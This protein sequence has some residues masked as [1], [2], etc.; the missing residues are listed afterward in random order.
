MNIIDF[1]VRPPFKNNWASFENP[2]GSLDLERCMVKYGMPYDKSMDLRSA[3][4]MIEDF[5][6]TGTKLA[7][8]AGRGAGG[9]SIEDNFEFAHQYEGRFVVFPYIDPT[10]PVR[11]LEETD[12]YVIHGE[13][14]GV[15]L[16]PGFTKTEP[17]HFDDPRACTLYEKLEKEGV[18]V[19]FTY[20]AVAMPYVDPASVLRLDMIAAKYPK[21]TM[22][23][24][25]AGWPWTLDCIAIAYR[26]K[27]VYLIPD[28]YAL[29]G[30]GARDY[31]DAINSN[32]KDK[33]I[34]GSSFPI[35]PIRST[36]QFIQ[37]N[38]NLMPDAEENF[39]YKNA[40]K[41]LGIE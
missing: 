31:I 4:K 22:V 39:F 24:A 19:M 7:V 27:N 16:E 30:P 18:P 5:D 37:Q 11:A 32:L 40:A 28:T 33:M 13:G 6:A 14:K 35:I 3:E 36:V 17:Y 23:I 15:N 38:W 2:D 41:I 9:A 12:R 34:Y 1:R 26:R 20:S 25:H 29:K 10:D 8:M 21:L